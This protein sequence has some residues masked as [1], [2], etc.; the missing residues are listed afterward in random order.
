[1]NKLERKRNFSKKKLIKDVKRV[2]KEIEQYK[3]IDHDFVQ[4]HL[5]W[6]DHPETKRCM[7]AYNVK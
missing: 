1:M 3:D 5:D 4:S 7:K 2:R 6:L